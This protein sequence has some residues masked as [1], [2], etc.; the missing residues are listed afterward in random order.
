MENKNCAICGT[1]LFPPLKD[2]VGWYESFGVPYCKQCY[3]KTPF[4]LSLKET[5]K[6]PLHTKILFGASIS[7]FVVVVL[8]GILQVAHWIGIF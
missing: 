7:L 5:W 3:E 2:A 1:Q 6:V 4:Y 8:S